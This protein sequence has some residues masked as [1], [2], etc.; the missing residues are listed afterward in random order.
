ML[1]VPATQTIIKNRERYTHHVTGEVYGGAD[2]DDAK[3]LA[4][5]GAIP[6]TASD[7]TKP[8]KPVFTGEAVSVAGDGKS[9]MLVKQ[10]RSKTAGELADDAKQLAA[11][12]ITQTETAGVAVRKLEDLIDLLIAKSVIKKEDLPAQAQ[13]WLDARKAER[14]KL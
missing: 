12:A 10:W 8:A 14:A 13:A 6:L 9:A 3:K 2:Y 11:Q 7:G 4:Q 5:I 1:Y